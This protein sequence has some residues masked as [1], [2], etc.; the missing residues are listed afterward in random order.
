MG[1]CGEHQV[2]YPD[3]DLVNIMGFVHKWELKNPFTMVIF[4][5][6][7]GPLTMSKGISLFL[8]PPPVLFLLW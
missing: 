6:T 1:C 7:R 4:L 3:F 2:L 5:P 8:F